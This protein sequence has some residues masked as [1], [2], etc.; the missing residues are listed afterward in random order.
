MAL[1]INN[2]YIIVAEIMTKKLAAHARKPRGAVG[3]Q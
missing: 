1:E 3:S 2:F